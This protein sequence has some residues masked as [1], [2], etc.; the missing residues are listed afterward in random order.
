MPLSAADRQWFLDR[1]KALDPNQRVVSVAA[2]GSRLVYSDAIRSDENK[3]RAADDEEL[4]RALTLCL[5]CSGEYGYEPERL[6]IEQ[7]H[8][9]GRPSTSSAQIDIVLY[10]LEEDGS[11]TVFAMWEV[12]NPSA[13]NSELETAVEHQLFGTAPLISPSLL[14][15]STILPQRAEIECMTIDYTAHKTFA[16]WDRA[17]RPHT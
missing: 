5:L 16:G 10:Y 12:K 2:Q 1:I 4:V 14:V 8:T 3:D 9:I 7:T 13:Y 6:Y 17:G 11:E 15:Y